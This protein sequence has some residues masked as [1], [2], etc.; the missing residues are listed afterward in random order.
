MK[1]KPNCTP[2]ADRPA[3]PAPPKSAVNV[4]DV[5]DPR[6]EAGPSAPV[7]RIARTA[8]F[9]PAAAPAAVRASRSGTQWTE[10]DHRARGRVRL[11]SVRISERAAERLRELSAGRGLSQSDTIEALI[12]SAWRER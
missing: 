5:R 7:R 10:A 1:R 4:P 8:V 6:P 3:A 9:R 2:S 11:G 12:D